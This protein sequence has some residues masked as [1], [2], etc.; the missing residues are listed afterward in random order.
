MSSITW[1]LKNLRGTHPELLQAG[2][3]VLELDSLLQSLPRVCGL[4]PEVEVSPR[5]WRVMLIEISDND[6]V[7]PPYFSLISWLWLIHVLS[8][9]FNPVSWDLVAKDCF[10]LKDNYI[11]N[12]CLLYSC[13][14]REL[15]RLRK[16]FH[17]ESWCWT[18]ASGLIS[19]Q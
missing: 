4:V 18:G 2:F 5:P 1:F 9:G 8:V 11:S 13:F 6:D 19:P 7:V 17:L 16:I 12:P 14:Q 10:I 15:K 3:L